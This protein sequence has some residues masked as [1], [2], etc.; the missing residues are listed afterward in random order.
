[1]TPAIFIVI[2]GIIMIGVI[3]YPVWKRRRNS[4]LKN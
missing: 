1:M 4:K 3:F 2:V